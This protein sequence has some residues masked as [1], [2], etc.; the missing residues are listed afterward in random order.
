MR[1]LWKLVSVLCVGLP[2][3]F[4]IS[5]TRAAATTLVITGTQDVTWKSDD[6]Q[7]SQ[8]DGHPL[9]VEVKK[10]DAIDIQIPSG[11]IPHGFI[12]INNRGDANPSPAPDLVLACGENPQSKP[13]KVLRETGCTGTP[14]VFGKRFAGTLK[15][16]VL[17]TFQAD[18]NF[19]CVVHKQGMWGMIK[20]KP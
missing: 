17:D 5:S 16:E 7:K 19:W 6:G 20:L 8:T 18:I 3:M 9:I 11:D 4:S 12:T 13:N 14:S 15:L 2:A 1:K 10:G